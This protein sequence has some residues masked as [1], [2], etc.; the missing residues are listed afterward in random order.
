MLQ[1]ALRT[2][3]FRAG[4][5]VAAFLAMFF[6]AIVLMACG[7]L[8]E[9]GIRAAV[10]PQQ[11]GS[12]DV[13]VAGDQTYRAPGGD[14]DEPAILP[15]RVRVDAGLESVI[16]ALPGVRETES[17]V[18]EGTPPAGTVDAIA[19]VAEPGVDVAALRTRID[20]ELDATTSTLVGDERGRAELRG[21]T[22]TSVNVVSLAGVFTAF[23]LLV[24][25][26]GVAS[27][28]G[29]S[30]AQRQ[31]E[32]AMLRAIGATPRQLRT[33]IFRETLVLSLV[34]TAAAYLPGQF[35]GRL[36]FDLLAQQ[37]IAT[38]GVAFH[39]GWI[40]SVAATAVAILAAL[41]GA[42]GAGRRAAR[43]KPSQAL[44]EAS[45]DGRLISGWRFLAGLLFVAAG[46]ALTIVTVTAL[47]G[48]LAPATAAPAVIVLSIGLAL[49]APVLAKVM[50]LLIQWPVRAL[51]GLTGDLAVL[52]ARGRT[53]RL[54]AVLGPVILLTGVSTGMLYLQTT[55]DA[56]D[57]EAFA[58][59]IVADAVVT[60]DGGADP[61]LVE[62]IG[63][64]PGV[65]GASAYVSSVGFVESPDDVSPMGEGWNLQGVTAQ[66]AGATTPVDVTA[67]ALTDLQGATVAIED[68][69][70]GRLGVDVGDTITLR[71]GDSTLLDVRVAALFSATEDYDT[72]LLPAETLADHTTAGFPTRVLVT[73]QASTD[74]EQLVATLTDL[75]AARDGL[76]VADR[77]ILFDEYEDQKKTASYAIYIMVLML[78]GYSAIT[79]INTL[80]SST[81][82]RQREFGLQ[83]LVGSTRRQVL[84][85]VGVEAAIVAV[86]GVVL[87]TAAALG[88]LVPLSLDRLGSLIPAGP[89]LVYVAIVGL[90]VL[91]TLGATLLPAWQATRVRPAEAAVSVE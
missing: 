37:G 50:I 60:A 80:V 88:I 24:S 79:T 49:L 17:Y 86:T 35:L 66:G 53:S 27:M 48:P 83:R 36:V 29:L 40:P 61:L 82:A 51:G 75:A 87:G 22:A 13:V 57:K 18:F 41:G 68:E 5:F 47:S 81:S 1:L 59:G 90:V 15:E 2:L 11:L 9:T 45:L 30:I 69:H 63:R 31:K 58:A 78:V 21:A 32:L 44:A 39:Q 72:L 84:E 56:A 25:I 55:N 54:A 74:P 10:P 28:L 14:E 52:N 65:A 38:V 70:A 89:P 67:G 34:A 76:T 77:E 19:V 20:A 26:F 73:A 4:T 8:I 23:G 46:V 7:G 71:M 42:L 91:L 85:M 16:S 62:E 6:A 43:T 12:A 64:L 33:L 3:R